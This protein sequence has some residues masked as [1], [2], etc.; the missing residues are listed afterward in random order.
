[1]FVLFA[2]QSKQLIS[3]NSSE[4]RGDRLSVPNEDQ[5]DPLRLNKVNMSILVDHEGRG[6]VV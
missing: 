6:A 5:A 2:I 4:S 3:K 1:M